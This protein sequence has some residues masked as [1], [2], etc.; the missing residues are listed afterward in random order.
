MELPSL[1]ILNGS[2]PEVSYGKLQKG[3]GL[4]SFLR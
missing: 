2:C 3:E 1:P 4:E